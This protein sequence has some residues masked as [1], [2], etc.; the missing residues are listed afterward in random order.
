MTS[1]A[2]DWESSLPL[3]PEPSLTGAYFRHAPPS[4]RFRP[5][6]DS[7]MYED[8]DTARE[9]EEAFEDWCGTHESNSAM[10]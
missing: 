3:R 10:Q 2:S 6:E 1:G 4:V 9:V 8:T 5:W 7:S